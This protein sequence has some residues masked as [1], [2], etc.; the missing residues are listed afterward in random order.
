MQDLPWIHWGSS[1]RPEIGHIII[2]GFTLHT[3]LLLQRGQ[4]RLNRCVC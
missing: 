2:S 1:I 4:L 3:W